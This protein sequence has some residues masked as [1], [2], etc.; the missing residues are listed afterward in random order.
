MCVCITSYKFS[1]VHGA[2]SI[3]DLLFGG[4]LQLK[5]A[6]VTAP[7]LVKKIIVIKI[8]IT[9]RNGQQIRPCQQSDETTDHI[10]HISMPNTGKRTLRK[11]T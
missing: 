7:V 10:I 3:V 5:N 2:L 1:V 11:K 9:N 6:V 4:H 8:N